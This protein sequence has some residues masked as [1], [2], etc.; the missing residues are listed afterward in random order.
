MREDSMREDSSVFY[1]NHRLII[2]FLM[3]KLEEGGG[4]KR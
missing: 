2:R 4:L 1:I 3:M